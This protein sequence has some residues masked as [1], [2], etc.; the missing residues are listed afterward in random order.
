M[1]S[2]RSGI[3]NDEGRYRSLRRSM[4]E[5]GLRESHQR[6]TVSVKVLSIPLMGIFQHG[7]DVTGMGNTPESSRSDVTAG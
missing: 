2:R 1:P 7:R 3:V 5:D 4:P 6:P